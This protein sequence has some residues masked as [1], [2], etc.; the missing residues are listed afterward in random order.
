MINKH[1]GYKD[2]NAGNYR[3]Q[4]RLPIEKLRCF[5]NNDIEMITA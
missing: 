4:A 3:K 1:S 2:C 5:N